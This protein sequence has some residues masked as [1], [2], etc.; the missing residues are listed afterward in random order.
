MGQPVLHGRVILFLM[1]LFFSC[2]TENIICLAFLW[3]FLHRPCLS[4]YLHHLSETSLQ[5]LTSV[6]KHMYLNV[7]S[8]VFHTWV[9]DW[10]SALARRSQAVRFIL[11][12]MKSCSKS[13]WFLPPHSQQ[14]LCK[15][16]ILM[17]TALIKAARWHMNLI[18][19]RLKEPLVPTTTLF[20]S[21]FPLIP[22]FRINQL[23]DHIV[24]SIHVNLGSCFQWNS[25]GNDGTNLPSTNIPNDR[26]PLSTYLNC[27]S[28]HLIFSEEGPGFWWDSHYSE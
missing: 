7:F 26:L 14:A 2:V 17:I 21:V 15:K 6:E 12:G 8:L 5:C 4:L 25:I 20:Q 10:I 18:R 13:A 24:S 27:A 9:G 11:T 23:S 19:G 22:I 16:P 28:G 3:S 1:F